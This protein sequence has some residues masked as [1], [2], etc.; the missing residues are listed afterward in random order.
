ELKKSLGFTLHYGYI[1]D[2]NRKKRIDQVTAAVYRAPKSYTGQESVEIFCH[3]SLPGIELIITLLK[4]VGFREAGPGEF[5]MRAFLNGKMDLSQAEA[6]AEIVQSK[7]RQAHSLAL[8]RLSGGVFDRIDTIKEKLV[9]L[10]SIIEV[11]L[12]Y[13]D[14]EIGGDTAVPSDSVLHAIEELETLIDTYRV[15]RIFHEG[16][17]VAF[18]GGTNAGKSSL[19]NLFLK[20]DRSIVS[21][22]NGT[23]RD[24][25]ESWISINGIPVRLFDTAG[26][27]NADHPV[28]LEGIRRSEEIIKNA[29][30]VLYVIDGSVG[31]TDED[32]KVFQEKGKGNEYMFIWNKIDESDKP[33]PKGVFPVSA[34]TGKGFSDLEKAISSGLTGLEIS[35]SELMIDSLRQKELLERAVAA[36]KGVKKSLANKVSLDAVALD[37]KDGLDALGEITGEVSSEDIL[38]NIFSGFCVGK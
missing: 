9:D 19:F 22:I 15:G 11:Q 29:A 21:E 38:N 6:V 18:A 25:I 1:V 24:Y 13:P 12:D 30:V 26:L 32:L 31:M 27:R 17:V 7:S 14:D 37:L 28:E 36:L 23:T 10:M 33:I 2:Q 5:T 16:V 20:E 3:G 35:G 8:N 34:V 4:D